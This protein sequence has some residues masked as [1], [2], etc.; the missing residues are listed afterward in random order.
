MR[1]NGQR[2]WLSWARRNECSLAG[3]TASLLRVSTCCAQPAMGVG[4]PRKRNR[5]VGQ[6]DQCSEQTS[7]RLVRCAW[8]TST[9]PAPNA[10]C[11]HPLTY[12]APAAYDP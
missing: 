6:C 8:S 7:D 9:L 10:Q 5:K 2:R 11:P 4:P 3:G 1:A 12:R